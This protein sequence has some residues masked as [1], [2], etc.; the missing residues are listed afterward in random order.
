MY[1]CS[2]RTERVIWGKSVYQGGLKA[3]DELVPKSEQIYD[4]FQYLYTIQV[5]FPPFKQAY[6]E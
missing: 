6:V 2:I 3:Y 1:P 4:E 5:I